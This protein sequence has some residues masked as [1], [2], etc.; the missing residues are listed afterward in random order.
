MFRL[1]T[2]FLI[3][4]LFLTACGEEKAKPD[5]KRL[6]QDIIPEIESLDKLITEEPNNAKLFFDRAQ[7]YYNNE[8]YQEAI[9]DL[10]KAIDLDSSQVD[11]YHLLADSYLDN[12][13]SREAVKVLKLC[14]VRFPNDTHTQLKLAEYYLILKQYEKS[15]QLAGTLLER[16]PS[17]PEGYFM[18]GM[19]YRAMQDTARA[20]NSFQAAIE[21]DAELIDAWLILGD[22]YSAENNDM[23]LDYYNGALTADPNNILAKHSKAYY[24]QNHG[25]IEQAQ[26]LYEEITL[27]DRSYILAPLNSG[28]LYLEEKNYEKALE[29]FNIII[30]NSPQNALGHYYRGLTHQALNQIDAAI[31][32][33]Q[34]SIN[35]DPTDLRVREALKEAQK[36][37]K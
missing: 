34:N 6:N 23:A 29:Q 25:D 13:K 27:A 19:N 3:S 14:M 26:K 2:L 33:F 17:N 30:G 11:Y 4:M 22:L 15:I 1:I 31:E 10:G 5:V 8:G 20:K 35:L 9:D 32:D 37:R 7:V 18:M 12:F 28:I 24:L 36:L 16:E 21:N